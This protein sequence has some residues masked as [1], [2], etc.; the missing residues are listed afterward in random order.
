MASL[1]GCVEHEPTVPKTPDC[2]NCVVHA[3]LS[4]VSW[5][6]GPA[7]AHHLGPV[8]RVLASVGCNNASQALFARLF[9]LTYT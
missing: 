5:S 4:G 8:A 9:Y 6:A 7:S 3:Q 2:G 1:V